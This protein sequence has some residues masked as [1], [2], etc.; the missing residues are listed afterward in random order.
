MRFALLELKVTS[1]SSQ[2]DLILCMQV[3][4]AMIVRHLELVPGTKTVKPLELDKAHAFAWIKGGLWASV[5]KRD[6]TDM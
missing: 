4:L 1:I 5:R 6:T 2:V 3:A